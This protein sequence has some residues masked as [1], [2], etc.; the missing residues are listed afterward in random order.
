MEK[1]I[2]QRLAGFVFKGDSKDI[3][4]LLIKGIRVNMVTDFKVTSVITNGVRKEG[5]R[6]K[7]VIANKV[8]KEKGDIFIK[9]Q[10]YMFV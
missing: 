4:R 8:S 9:K 10:F 1:L 6:E 2:E 3:K 5:V 7:G